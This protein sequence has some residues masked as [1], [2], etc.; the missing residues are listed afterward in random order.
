MRAPEPVTTPHPITSNGLTL[1]VL[2]WSAPADAWCAVVLV[3]SAGGHCGAFSELGPLLGRC[4]IRAFAMNMAGH[5]PSNRAQGVVSVQ[6]MVQ[7]IVAAATYA[8]QQTRLPVAVLGTGLGGEYAFHALLQ[9][10]TVCAAVCHGL[11]LSFIH[12]LN[13]RA[14]A[15]QT[16]LAG[17][18][19]RWRPFVSMALNRAGRSAPLGLSS[20]HFQDTTCAITH[21][22]L[23]ALRSVL[24]TETTLPP[25]ANYKPVLVVVGERDDVIPP[26]HALRCFMSVGG[27]K[28]FRVIPGATHHL[29]EDHAAQLVDVVYGFLKQSVNSQHRKKR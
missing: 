25:G 4:G 29:V 5:G 18:I 19:S 21:H 1:N 13:W 3:P 8:A 28:E 20:A 7:N 6:Q 12:P 17:V 23:G 2:E 15:M 16:R 27:P 26:A 22:S 14:R 10:Q 11:L 9:S 24:T